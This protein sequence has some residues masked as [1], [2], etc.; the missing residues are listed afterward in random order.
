MHIGVSLPSG[1]TS[2]WPFSVFLSIL[3]V[4]LVATVGTCANG[5][6]ARL[7]AFVSNQSKRARLA[8][9][10]RHCSLALPLSNNLRTSLNPVHQPTFTF[11]FTQPFNNVHLNVGR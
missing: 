10:C 4:L 5:P 1:S 2:S 6:C 7:I 9:L 11:A 8:G 3:L